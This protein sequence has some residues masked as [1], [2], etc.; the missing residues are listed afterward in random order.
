MSAVTTALAV[1][2]S[3]LAARPAQRAARRPR[4][5]RGR[6]SLSEEPLL[7]EIEAVIDDMPTYGYA[8]V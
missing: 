3:H 8:R 5:R 6:P 2:R 7:A 4:E 1:A